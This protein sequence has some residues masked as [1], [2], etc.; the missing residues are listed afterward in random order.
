M[1]AVLMLHSIDASGSVLSMTQ[2]ELRSLVQAVRRSG[3]ELLPLT[4]LLD[5]DSQKRAVALT[6]DDGM[7]TLVTDAAPVLREL[8][9]PATLFLTTGYVGKDNGWP[10][11]PPLAPRLPIMGW[12]EL[13]T[14][15]QSGWDIQAHT[16]THP[17]LRTQSDDAALHELTE[18][19]ETIARRLGHKP[20]LLAYP[21]GYFDRRIEALTSRVYGRALSTRMALLDGDTRGPLAVP[22]LDTYY[23]RSEA[24][25]RHFGSKRFRAYLEARALLRRARKHPGEC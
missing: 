19:V 17:D 16:V 20:S 18:P 25:H 14:L 2:S 21:Y 8:G 11:Q 1:R 12:D 5:D 9:V 10:S 24:V 6:F 15:K 13:E 22:R 4:Q 23:F 7:R 3:H